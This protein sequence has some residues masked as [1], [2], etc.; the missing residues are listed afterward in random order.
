MDSEVTSLSL[1]KGLTAAQISGA[2]AITTYNNASNNRVITSVDSTTV[3][4][5]DNLTFDGSTLNVDGKLDIDYAVSAGAV[6]DINNTY[7]GVMGTDHY[8]LKVTGGQASGIP[9]TAVK[10]YGGYFLAGD[11]NA[12]NP[13]SIALYAQGHED[14][15]PNSYAAI[16]SG[17]TGGVVGIN[18]ME[19]TV[20]LDVVGDISASGNVV[21]NAFYGDGSNLTGLSVDI[22]SDTNLAGGTNL[23]LSGDTMNLDDD[24]TLAATGHRQL[25]L[26]ANTFG[27]A[28]IVLQGN[29]TA[30]ANKIDAINKNLELQRA[31]STIVEIESTG[32]DVTGNI[33]ASG[34]ISIDGFTSVSASLATIPTNNNQLTNGAGYLT[35][36]DISSNTN[37]VGGTNLTLSGD[38]MNMDASINLT[39]VAIGGYTTLS[40]TGTL[41]DIGGDA[42]WAN[43][44]Y[45]KNGSP[46]HTF[47]GNIQAND[48]VNVTGNITGSNGKFN[49]TLEIQGIS[50]VSA[51]IAAAGSGG[52]GGAV[53]AVA[54]G[55]NNRV[56]TFSSTDAL[57]GEANMTFDGSTL[58]VTGDIRA[59]GDVIARYSSD[60]T[61]KKNI[62]TLEVNSSYLDINGVRFDWDEEKQNRYQGHD[63]GFIAQEIEQVFPEAVGTRHDGTKAVDYHK[64]VPPL[65]EMVKDLHNRLTK[66]E[67]GRS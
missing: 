11:T 31:G 3:N 51:S 7:S 37:L 64:L 48:D 8:A 66:L 60:A 30:G 40:G 56:A 29:T 15:P 63:I 38:T 20:E 43:I 2:A 10:A 6:A 42:S 44:R 33:T 5:E 52:G 26:V 55:S 61:L 9:G 1:I 13:D 14:G 39:S 36:V 24:I 35:T 45:G 12:T 50:N 23:T 25:K 21:A 34:D 67:N 27:S 54:N 62:E 19:P 58:D 46:T 41:L 59:T 22:S 16:F 17:S 57:N 65:W 4:S 32:I 49:G 18:T 47:E 28:S 53:S